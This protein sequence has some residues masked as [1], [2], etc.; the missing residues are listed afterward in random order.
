MHPP[1]PQPLG[2][3]VVRVGNEDKIFSSEDGRVGGTKGIGTGA[4][5]GASFSSPTGSGWKDHLLALDSRVSD[6]NTVVHTKEL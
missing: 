2:N 1:N 5:S 6:L 4:S 3:G